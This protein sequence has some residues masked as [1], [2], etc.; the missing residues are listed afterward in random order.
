[1]GKRSPF[2]RTRRPAAGRAPGRTGRYSTTAVRNFEQPHPRMAEARSTAERLVELEVLVT[3]LA[4]DL[5]SLN[6]A[7]VAQQ[8][9]LDA[10]QKLM[11]G[12]DA[13]V[14]RLDDGDEQRDPLKERP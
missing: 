14:N 3:H 11:A 10:L 13:R 2:S 7:L 5:E 9:Q 1:M 6:T 4:R 8:K 12:L